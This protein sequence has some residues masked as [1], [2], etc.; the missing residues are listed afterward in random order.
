MGSRLLYSL[1]L[2][3]ISLLPYP[4]LYLL[5]DCIRVVL[6]GVIGYRLKVIEG[7]I[8]RSF[9]DKTASEQKQISK[10]FQKHFCDII[11]ESLKN[12]SISKA[13]A[14]KRMLAINAEIFDRYKDRNIAIVGGHHNNWELYAVAAALHIPVP[15]MA[16]YKRLSN[17]YFDEKMRSSRGKYGLKLI[18]TK[19]SS[20]WMRV[21][22]KEPKA[23]VYGIDQSPANPQKA[24]WMNWLNQETAM[25]FGAEKHAKDFNMV[26]IFGSCR[27]IKRGF[28]QIA[29]ELITEDP[30]SFAQ[31]MIIQSIN[32]RL[33]EDI[34]KEPQH[35]LWTHKRWKH[36]RPVGVEL[37]S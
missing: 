26:V 21:H 33:E 24:Y 18:P 20:E 10:D 5:S 23:V 9:P 15:L 30:N 13:A 3:P 11:V 17:R 4:L 7:N 25:Y 37:H 35:Y 6:F 29:Y 19:E 12:F 36:K 27:K 22:A 34:K 32:E 8:A 28:Y 1:V 2:Y 14:N 31:G 16:I